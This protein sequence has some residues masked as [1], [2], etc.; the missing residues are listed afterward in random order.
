MPQLDG[1][2]I[3]GEDRMSLER[4]FEEEIKEA[5]WDCGG[6]EEPR[7]GWVWKPI[8]YDML[9]HYQEGLTPIVC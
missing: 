8:L 3:D 1:S 9:G 7:S 2:R 5:I 6:R 4:C